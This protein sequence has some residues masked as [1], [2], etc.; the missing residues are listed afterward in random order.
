MKCKVYYNLKPGE[1]EPTMNKFFEDESVS[2]ISSVESDF[3]QKSDNSSAVI[4]KSKNSFSFIIFY[5]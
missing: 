5:E 4:P 3:F 2:K 1:I